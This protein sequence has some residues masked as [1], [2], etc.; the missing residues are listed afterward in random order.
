MRIAF[1]LAGLALS[2]VATGACGEPD[3]K[4]A[5]A[6]TCA[7][8]LPRL[9]EARTEL[10]VPIDS[11]Q[12]EAAGAAWLARA[13]QK[14]SEADVAHFMSESASWIETTSAADLDM[15]STTCLANAPNA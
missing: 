5:D 8:Y 10:R 2:V 13:E 12:L 15:I 6:L 7:A 1:G 11:A 9:A 4:Y 3:F 14:F